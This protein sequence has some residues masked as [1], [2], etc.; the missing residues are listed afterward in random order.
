MIC[1]IRTFYKHS[2]KYGRNIL[3]N[4]MMWLHFSD[5]PIKYSLFRNEN[6]RM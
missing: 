5:F 1:V 4:N 3:F 6:L 2:S